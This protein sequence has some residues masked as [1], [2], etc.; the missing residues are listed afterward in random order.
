VTDAP[1][2]ARTPAPA[3]PRSG[4]AAPR[5]LP[6]LA[7]C[8]LTVGI[9]ALCA[10]EPRH[11]WHHLF[12]LRVYQGAVA[13]WTDGRA[14]YDFRYHGSAYGFTYPPFAALVMSPMAVLPLPLVLAGHTLL[15]VAVLVGLA[16]W[17]V[18]PIAR[19]HG[20][21]LPVTW[22]AAVPVLYVL[23]P[24]RETIGYGQIN[25]LLLALVLADCAGLG[26]GSRWAGVGIGL[27][28]ALKVTPALFVPYLLVTGR[29]RA[30]GVAAATAAVA[31]LLAAAVAPAASW[32]YWT[33]ALWETDRVGRTDKTDN[34]SV[35]GGLARLT[36]PQ[37]PSRVL[38]AVLVAVLLVV[39]FRR[40]ARAARAG[41]ELAALTLVG[42]AADLVSPI[43]WTHHLVWVAPALVVLVDVAAGTRP[44]GDA[45]W[46][47][48]RAP[49]A[50]AAVLSSGVW[51][52]LAVSVVWFASAA[53][54][55]H[56]DAGVGG[57]VVEDAYLLT[58][59]VLVLL[60]PIRSGQGSTWRSANARATST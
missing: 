26:R 13:W 9:A 4:P 52:L 41:D 32:Q 15:N 39:V 30:A 17:L 43:S 25:L 49:R 36:D 34:Q 59:V 48:R 12:D 56:H 35:L 14:L 50:L 2:P 23:E 24:V 16:R 27:A 22:I 46:W 6:V 1:E 21:Q 10:L 47:W 42:L 3:A 28:A 51:L 11:P 53:A 7:V 29:R 45:A 18:V 55:E 38:W 57:L 54:G 19:R 20:W 40:A 33:R 60:L 5:A 8:A 31:T 44:A 37:P 58:L